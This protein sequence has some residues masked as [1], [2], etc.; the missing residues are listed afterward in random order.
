M[1]DAFTFGIYTAGI[2]VALCLLV[3]LLFLYYDDDP[4]PM[5]TPIWMVYFGSVLSGPSMALL[6]LFILTTGR[7]P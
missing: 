2:G 3:V 5:P 4:F 7:I 6:G 1:T